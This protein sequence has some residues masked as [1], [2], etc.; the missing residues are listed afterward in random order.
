M[1]A[2]IIG[3]GE[4]Y[5][6]ERVRALLHPC[7]LL[8]CA[9]GGV[10]HAVR[11][12]LVPD[13]IL[14][15][16]D[17]ASPELIAELSGRGIPVVRVPVEKDQTD[18]HL[19]LDEA[20]RRGAT[21]ILLVG[22]SGHRLDHTLSNLLLLPAVPEPVE[23]SLADGQNIVRLLRP[24]RS[25][26]VKGLP[27]EF[28]SLLPLSPEVTGVVACGVK[29]PLDGATLRWGISLGVSN[30]LEGTEATVSIDNGYLLVISAW[31]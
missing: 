13:L 29:W 15:D 20:L 9:D 10:R 27:G 16:F 12:G 25:M 30:R 22:G 26:L 21:E 5:S 1:K 23:V 4:I 28:L 6:D 14:G 19:A 18:T 31:D 2:V 17:S 8:I 11:L 3:A 7:D 24:G